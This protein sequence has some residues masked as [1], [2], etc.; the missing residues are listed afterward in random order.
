M[1]SRAART[2]AAGGHASALGL[3]RP[4]PGLSRPRSGTASALGLSRPRPGTASALGLS[5]P[6]P[7]TASALG[8]SRPRSGYR[9]G[10]RAIASALRLSLR[11]IASAPRDIAPGDRVR[12]RAIAP[13]DRFRRLGV[14][15]PPSRLPGVGLIAAGDGVDGDRTSDR[16]GRRATGWTY[17][18]ERWAGSPRGAGRRPRARSERAD[19]PHQPKFTSP[20][21]PVGA[22]RVMAPVPVRTAIERPGP[23]I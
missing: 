9:V 22:T 10:A 8:L 13:G 12:A 20:H 23:C 17:L 11:A 3:S 14:R 19:L 1:A 21:R 16:L 2:R 5:R 7:G 6:R 4:R 15:R 18:W